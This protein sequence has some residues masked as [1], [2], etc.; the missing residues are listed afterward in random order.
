MHINKTKLYKNFLDIKNIANVN[1][2]IC[3]K[4]LLK[5]DGLKHN[6]GSYIV[7]TIIIFHII[8]IIIFYVKSYNILK[9]KIKDIAFAIKNMSLV[10]DINDINKEDKK[11]NK[12]IKF[13][14]HE[15]KKDSSNSRSNFLKINKGYKNKTIKLKDNKKKND[16][17]VETKNPIGNNI[18]NLKQNNKRK[19]NLFD[20]LFNVSKKFKTNKIN[21]N[22]KNIIQS[23][24][25]KLKTKAKSAGI[26]RSKKMKEEINKRIINTMKY[27]DEEKNFLDFDLAIKYDKRKYCK[28]YK[29]L[30]KT[31]HELIFSFFHKKDYNA[32]IIKI[33][34]YFISFVIFYT[35]NGLFFDDKT[36]HNIYVKK[37]S[38]DFE[39]QIPKIIYS[40]LISMVIN[41]ILGILA[42]S[43]NAI[44]DFKENKN[45]KN[46]DIRKNNLEANL[47]LKFLLYFI[48]SFIFLLLFWYY[49]TLFGAIY[50]NTQMHLLKD[51]LISFGLSL[52]Y[53]FIIYLF[54]GMFRIPALAKQKAKRKCLYNFSK[55][56]QIF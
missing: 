53:P 27:I 21:R 44:I 38:F 36:M 29:S 32:R 9:K 25:N 41:K 8:T 50:L 24:E 14:K 55:F 35:V 56:L 23:K 51:T 1:I 46:V 7:T 10:K 11:E 30:L 6:I 40:S 18:L 20:N 19:R 43:S 2:L 33:D 12:K 26:K 17:I 37:G 31:Q 49:I 3:Y 15:L 39:Y 34:L 13:K 48:L 5:K 16:H 4:N 42:F 28:Y 54:P 45:K 52:I 47:R 22:K